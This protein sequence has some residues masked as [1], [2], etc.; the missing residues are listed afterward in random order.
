MVEQFQELI[1]GDDVIVTTGVGQHQMWAMQYVLTERPRNFIT[2]GGLGTMGYG[3]PAAIG[4]KAARPEATVVCIDGDGCFQ[5]TSQELVTAVLDDLP[6][7]I[8]LLNNGYLGMVTQWQDMFFDGRRSHVH[9]TQAVPDYAKL[10][11]AYGAVGLTVNEEDELRPA[12]LEA[13]SCGRPVVIDVRCDPGRALLPDDPDRGCRNR[14]ARVHGGGAVRMKHTISVTVEDKPG[15]LTRITT[16]FAR[17]GFNIDS[18]AVGPTERPGVSCIT[19]RVDCSD[20]SLEQIE[21]Q[22]HKLVNVLRVTELVADEAVER[23]LLLVKVAAPADKRAELIAMA[24]SLHASVLDLGPDAILLE[25]VGP[26]RRGRRVPR[27]LQAVRNPGSDPHRPHRHVAA[28][29]E[30]QRPEARRGDQL[31][32]TASRLA[33]YI[34]QP[35]TR[36]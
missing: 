32:A 15:A 7:V 28:V 6:V 25:L 23:E 19:L 12:L 16:M 3:I 17:R 20:H 36:N 27:A 34:S 22:I 4:A 18:L 29:D 1:A 31:T 10:A 2:S 5:M 30:A 13:L 26:A 33:R 14:H 21:K 35:L 9:L 11:E 24:E 8:L